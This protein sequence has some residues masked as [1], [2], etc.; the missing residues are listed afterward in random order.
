M[1]EILK[2]YDKTNEFGRFLNMTYEVV[3]PGEVVFSM[4]VTKDLLATTKAMH[5]GALAGLMD[6]VVGVAALSVSSLKDK[7]VSTVEFKINYLKPVLLNDQLK[8]LGTVISEGNRIIVCKGE[9][10]NQKE[11]LVAIA[12]STMNA[13]PFTKM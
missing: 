5:G 8:G 1:N 6:A 12:T 7:L 9:I 3:Q 11:E 10:F 13:Y 2:A 4:L